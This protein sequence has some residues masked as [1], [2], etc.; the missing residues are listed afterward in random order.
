MENPKIL[1][2]R[3]N[4]KE[5]ISTSQDERSFSQNQEYFHNFQYFELETNLENSLLRSKSRSNFKHIEISPK[6]LQSYL[7]DSL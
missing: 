7:L 2:R 4:G 3:R 6:R 1:I 5:Q